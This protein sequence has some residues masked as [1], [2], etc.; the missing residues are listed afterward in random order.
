MITAVG[1]SAVLAATAVAI[2]MLLAFGLAGERV[3]RVAE[4]A[5]LA[6]ADTLAGYVPGVSPCQA[7][8]L[9]AHPQGAA[10]TECLIDGSNVTVRV[11][12]H[13]SGRGGV[14]RAGPPV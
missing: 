12:D 4:Q 9:V 11:V 5:A 13:A 3:Q 7:A 1:A 10:M 6:A 8:E 2:S 14:A